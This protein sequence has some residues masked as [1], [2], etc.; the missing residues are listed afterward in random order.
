MEVINILIGALGLI[1]MLAL[2]WID[3]SRRIQVKR[4][5]TQK[6]PDLTKVLELYGRLFPPDL[7]NY[8]MADMEA[9]L[10]D[11]F[12]KEQRRHV[13][14]THF[15]LAGKLH[16]DVVSFLFCH[17]YPNRRKAIVSYMGSDKDAK[18]ARGRA[19]DSLVRRLVR[20]LTDQ[21]PPCTLLLFECDRPIPGLDPAEQREREARPFLFKRTA[22]DLGYRSFQ[23]PVDFHQPKLNLETPEY[24]APLVLVT[25]L[26]GTPMTAAIEDEEA[27]TAA[28]LDFLLFDAYGDYY[29][30]DDPRHEEY[31][32][33]LREQRARYLARVS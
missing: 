28:T 3:R 33:Y 7:G 29:S 18:E 11:E 9:L 4:I 25:I 14:E 6:D 27:L 22:K 24:G 1:A 13:P 26:M 20:H 10:V 16:G 12:G 21:S 8:T 17:Y 19:V 5:T 32:A 31:Q 30:P 23:L 2:W 15:V